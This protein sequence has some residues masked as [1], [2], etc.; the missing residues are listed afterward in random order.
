MRGEE[1]NRI[2]DY[3]DTAKTAASIVLLAVFAPLVFI[4]IFSQQTVVGW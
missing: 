1:M 2:R 3:I 4:W